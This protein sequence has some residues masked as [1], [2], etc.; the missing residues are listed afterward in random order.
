MHMQSATMVNGCGS[1]HGSAEERDEGGRR[2]GWLAMCTLAMRA[3]VLGRPRSG[4]LAS[5]AP[6]PDVLRGGKEGRTEQDEMWAGVAHARVAGKRTGS[7]VGRGA[8]PHAGAQC[9]V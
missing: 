6:V 8:R 9:V 5:N 7:C 2:G 4:L 3:R 1:E